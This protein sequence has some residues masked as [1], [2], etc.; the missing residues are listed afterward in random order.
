MDRDGQAAPQTLTGRNRLAR[1]EASL[2]APQEGPVPQATVR[3]EAAQYFLAQLRPVPLERHPLAG[4][5]YW[6]LPRRL[7]GILRGLSYS[8]C[9]FYTILQNADVL[10]CVRT[11]TGVSAS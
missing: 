10:P 1:S 7:A 8:P 6:S 9:L 3:T 4:P 2:P 11:R 5:V